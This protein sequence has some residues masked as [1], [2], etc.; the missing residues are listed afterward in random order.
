MIAN[1][2][3]DI[4]ELFGGVLELCGGVLEL[5]GCIMALFGCVLKRFGGVVGA[6]RVPTAPRR[7]PG[8]RHNSIHS[9]GRGRP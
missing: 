9:W 4:N 6:A 1:D 2:Y 7:G 8:I 5:F 3:N